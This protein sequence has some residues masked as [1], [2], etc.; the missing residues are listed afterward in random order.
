MPSVPDQEV[1]VR[2]HPIPAV[3]PSPRFAARVAAGIFAGEA[4][5]LTAVTLL[6]SRSEGLG[7]GRVAIP[8][9]CT[10]VAAFLYT[11][12]IAGRPKL[13]HAA[14]ALG[15]VLVSVNALSGGNEPALS[16]GMLYV[17]LACS[18]R[19]SSARA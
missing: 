3:E 12:E 10:L 4:L 18:Q 15:T 5:V 16:G 17:W 1:G 9:V 7:G 11:S 8:A 19:T 6:S 2:V 13:L 14:T